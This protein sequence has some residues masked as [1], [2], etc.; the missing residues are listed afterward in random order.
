V[1]M[2]LALSQTNRLKK[3]LYYSAILHTLYVHVTCWG[4]KSFKSIQSC[5]QK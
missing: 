5:F 4:T 3:K 2:N 1:T